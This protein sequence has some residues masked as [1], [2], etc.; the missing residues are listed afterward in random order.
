M[1][2]LRIEN[3][4]G[5]FKEFT[6]DQGNYYV[7]GITGLAYPNTVVNT[8]TGGGVDG[9]FHNSS[10]VEQRNLVIDIV[11]N[12]DIETN[13]QQLYRFFNIKKPCTIYFKNANRDVKIIG[14]VEILDGDFF[15]QRERMQ[16]SIICPRPYFEDMNAI[17]AEISTSLSEFEFPFSI[18]FNQ[19]VPFSELS[20]IPSVILDNTGD[21]DVGFIAQIEVR[22]SIDRL[23][24]IN[25]T[26][27]EQFVLDLTNVG[28]REGCVI[29]LDTRTGHMGV[30]VTLMGI[31]LNLINYIVD[32]SKWLKLLPGENELT[33]TCSGG[34]DAV[35]I[36]FTLTA[37][38]GGV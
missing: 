16:I 29:T 7:V 33:F 25:N 30:S 38:Y 10:R 8:A 6:H 14:Y 20:D 17:E 19:P 18:N 11:L 13:R 21:A 37:L 2:T 4:R 24:I 3:A 34:Y 28:V 31:T 35:N 5:E 1:F 32:G 36:Y 27:V 26:T 23:A 12:G 15:V 22:E 9:S